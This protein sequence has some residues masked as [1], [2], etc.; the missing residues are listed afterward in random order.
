MFLYAQGVWLP[1]GDG[2]ASPLWNQRDIEYAAID[3]ELDARNVPGEIPVITVDP[4]SFVNDTGRRSIYLPT[5]SVDAIFDAARQFGARYL[6][7][8]YDKPATMRDLYDGKITVSGLNKIATVRDGL[9]RPV[10]L[11]EVTR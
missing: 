2:A 7:L 10:T 1:P 5:E 9:G 6:V 11:F 3:A 8:Q 4:P